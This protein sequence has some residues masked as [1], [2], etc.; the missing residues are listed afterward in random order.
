MSIRNLV[1]PAGL[2]L[3]LVVGACANTTSSSAEGDSVGLDKDAKPVSCCPEMDKAHCDAAKAA[4]K[5]EGTKM[6]CDSA[7]QAECEAKAAPK[8]DS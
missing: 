7:K 1:L 5:C 6:S 8:A 3:A 2:A 4:G